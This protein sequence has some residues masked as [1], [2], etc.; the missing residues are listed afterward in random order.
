MEQNEIYGYSESVWSGAAAAVPS[1]EPAADAVDEPLIDT[2]TMIHIGAAILAVAA[3]VL[4]V[5]KLTSKRAE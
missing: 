3:A 5:L 4:T 1:P 2:G